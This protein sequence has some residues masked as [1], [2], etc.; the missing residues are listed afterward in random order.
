MAHTLDDMLWEAITLNDYSCV[1][2]LVACKADVNA[3]DKD[4]D[5]LLTG[6]DVDATMLQ[7]LID[8]HMN[9]NKYNT[10]GFGWTI[11]NLNPDVVMLMVAAKADV[12]RNE[13]F[14]PALWSIPSAASAEMLVMAK[15]N[16]DHTDNYGCS[17]LKYWIHCPNIV[18]VLLDA[19]ATV[20]GLEIS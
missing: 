7:L 3:L 11:Q 1:R 2:S 19:K 13:P 15:A 17:A 12:N 16:I 14:H 9:V 20:P 18:K 8:S 6:E 4:G 5:T 10:C